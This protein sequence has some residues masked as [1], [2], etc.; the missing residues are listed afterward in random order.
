MTAIEEISA[1]IASVADKVGPSVVGVN[2]HG[3]GLVVA[4]GLV[5]T[6]AHNIRVEKAFVTFADGRGAIGEAAGVDLDG[7]LAVIAVD[8]GGA[9]AVEWSDTPVAIGQVVVALSNPRGRGLRATIGTISSTGRGFRGPRGR[10]IPGSI[11]H[12]APLAR[13]SS[14]GPVLDC[15]G[16]AVGVNTNRVQEGFYQAIAATEELVQRIDALSKGNAPQRRR[17]GTAIAP[18]QVTKRLR[19]AAGLPEVEGLLVRGV[20][21]GSPAEKA[22]LRR[23]DVLL[24]AGGVALTSIDALYEALD[25]D[26]TELELTVARAAEE[27]TVR[28]S[29]A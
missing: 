6:N 16:R 23:G 28:V 27:L 19:A 11:E 18:P 17:L 15:E 25:G 5:V 12:T 1:T 7:D 20:E 13:G 24:S 10:R 9:P 21:D 2:R 8:T 29:F 26:G 4:D 22:G 14:G 3:T